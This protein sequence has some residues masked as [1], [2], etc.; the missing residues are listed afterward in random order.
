MGISELKK[1]VLEKVKPSKEE[2]GKEQEFAQGIIGK[3]RE[4]EGNHIEFPTAI[5]QGGI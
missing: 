3:I 4:I 5:E 1:Q 2:I